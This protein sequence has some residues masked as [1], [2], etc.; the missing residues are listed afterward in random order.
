MKT[1]SK[2]ISFTENEIRTAIG[3]IRFSRE[4]RKSLG[5]KNVKT[6]EKIYEKLTDS[7]K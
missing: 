1:K 5:I 6:L 3:A 7:I 2:T 4:A